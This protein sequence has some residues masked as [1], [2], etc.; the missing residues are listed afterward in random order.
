MNPLKAAAAMLA[1]AATAPT[2][3]LEASWSGF[4]TLGYARSNSPYV[5][6]RSINDAGTIRRDSLA[7]GQL[8]LTF[9]PH[10]SATVQAQVA[11]AADDDTRWA[12]KAA[13]AFVAWR[14]DNDWLLR[15]GKARVPLYL[16]SES[17]DIGVAYDMA[18][19]PY[20]VYSL[21]PTN[22]FTG[23][24]VTRNFPRGDGDLTLDAYA[25]SA[26]ARERFW[27]R[28]GVPSMQP[29][30]ANFIVADVRIHGLILTAR[31]PRL[32]WR[33]GAHAV[34]TRRSDG[35]AMPVRFPRVDVAPGLYYW[36]VDAALPGPGIPTVERVHNLIGTAGIEWSFGDGWRAAGE[37]VRIVQRDTELGSDSRAAY[38]ALFRRLGDFTPYVSLARQRSTAA[39]IAWRTELIGHAL[40]AAFPGAAMINAA[41]RVAGESLVAVDQGSVALGVAW[42]F[43]PKAKL[44]AEWMRTHIGTTSSTFDT[45]AGMPDAQDQNVHTLSLSVNVAF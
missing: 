2:L 17:L 31:E 42:A 3:A 41:Q 9:D 21:S 14:P 36:Q 22:D 30:G 43:S 18:R 35:Q 1:L 23:L 4:A 7:A 10:W 6:Q 27:W 8:D 11:Q 24:F 39:S 32:T 33:L 45:P 28:D 12:A 26:T 16:Y 34:S 38:L 20:E 19:M 29:A 44:K 37:A 40:P 15:L 13:W 25:G 5:Y